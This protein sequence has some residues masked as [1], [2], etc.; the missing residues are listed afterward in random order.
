MKSIYEGPDEAVVP[1]YFPSRT[2]IKCHLDK[3]AVTFI[4]LNE[5]EW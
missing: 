3:N 4:Q 2:Q 1:S 5:A